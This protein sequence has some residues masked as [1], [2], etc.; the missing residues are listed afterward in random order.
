VL[1]LA[2]DPVTKHLRPFIPEGE[3][4]MIWKEV[5]AMMIE[6]KEAAMCV[7][8]ASDI[9]GHGGAVAVATHIATD[10]GRPVRQ[11]RFNIHDN[12]DYDGM[13]LFDDLIQCQ[14]AGANNDTTHAHDQIEMSCRDELMRYRNEVGLAMFRDSQN[15]MRE[16]EFTDPLQ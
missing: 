12:D 8:T 3:H 2:F 7:T 9:G 10:S 16:K 15:G 4:D 11:A 1:A 14:Q 5:L 6:V 13:D